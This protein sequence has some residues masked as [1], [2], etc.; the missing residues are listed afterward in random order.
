VA[1][2]E[3]AR[4]HSAERGE[5][6]KVYFE[7]W[8]EPMISGIAWISELISVPSCVALLSRQADWRRYHISANTDVASLRVPWAGQ[9][10]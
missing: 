9:M 8:D 7:E 1:N 2:L 4:Q 6:P 10:S 3:R 5:R